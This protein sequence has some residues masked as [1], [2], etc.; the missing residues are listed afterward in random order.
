V[1][2]CWSIRSQFVVAVASFLKGKSIP[3]VVS[4]QSAKFDKSEFGLKTRV[5]RK[6]SLL[7]TRRAGAHFVACSKTV[8]E[9]LLSL[10]CPSDR[11]ST[12]F[13][14]VEVEADW[15]SMNSKWRGE[16]QG[17]FMVC[18]PAR[19]HPQKNHKSLLRAWS[20][21]QQEF[22]LAKLQLAGRGLVQTNPE[23]AQM[24]QDLELFGVELLGEL[25]DVKPLYSESDFV[26]FPAISGEGLS[27]GLLEAMEQGLVPLVADIP[28]NL[29]AVGSAGFAFSGR[30]PISIANAIRN[31]FSL[32]SEDYQ[33]HSLVAR[34]RVLEYFDIEK[35]AV[36]FEQIWSDLCRKL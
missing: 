32:S 22:P 23:V 25:H 24:I 10:G 16:S 4:V 36:E 7:L 3:V 9:E 34:S 14:S 11:T 8:H 33:A 15:C 18:Y 1:V 20:L 26:C 5:G 13:N 29:E 6:I 19:W 2:H 28:Q 17:D 35:A 21:V 12:V 31:A 27:L 30:D